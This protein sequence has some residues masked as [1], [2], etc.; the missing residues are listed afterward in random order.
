MCDDMV[1]A[2]YLNPYSADPNQI[3]WI[4]DSDS[5]W[6]NK[7]ASRKCKAYGQTEA[8]HKVINDTFDGTGTWHSSMR[9]FNLPELE[10]CR[11][12]EFVDQGGK[13]IDDWT[14]AKGFLHIAAQL[15][16]RQLPLVLPPEH[17]NTTP[18]PLFPRH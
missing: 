15:L 18:E 12:A 17:G 9:M 2:L 16:R 8:L 5:L 14:H 3:L 13:R 10:A 1:V 4:L 7:N 11:C 6:F